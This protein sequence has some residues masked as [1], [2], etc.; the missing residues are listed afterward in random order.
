VESILEFLKSELMVFLMAVTPLIELRGSLPYAIVVLGMGYTHAYIISVAGSIIP[1][2][3]ILKLLPKV[4]RF[5]RGKRG[6]DKIADWITRRTMRKSER[7]KKITLLG[8]FLFVAIPLPGTGVWTGSA[9]AA[10][11][12]L[13]YKGAFMACFLGTMVAGLLMLILSH[14]GLMVF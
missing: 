12:G 5:L 9:I 6:F 4:L 10:L 11:L 7:M 3:F 2:P 14:L 8:L 1:S 13:P